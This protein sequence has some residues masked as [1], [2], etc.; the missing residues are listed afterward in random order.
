[1]VK[2]YEISELE[3]LSRKDLQAT[4]KE[5]GV[6]ANQSSVKIIQDI[7]DRNVTVEETT[8]HEE[9]VD[10]EITES[11]A[12]FQQC[13]HNVSNTIVESTQHVD[14]RHVQ[15]GLPEP[16]LLNDE[17]SRF[18]IKR[19]NKKS[20]KVKSMKP[21]SEEP[22]VRVNVSDDQSLDTHIEN[23]ITQS[24]EDVNHY[25]GPVNIEIN[26]ENFTFAEDFPNTGMNH[27]SP[28][29]VNPKRWS[30]GVTPVKSGF[31]SSMRRSSIGN[32]SMRFSMDNNMIQLNIQSKNAPGSSQKRISMDRRLSSTPSKQPLIVPKLNK[33][34]IARQEAAKTKILKMQN[35]SL[36]ISDRVSNISIKSVALPS[37]TSCETSQRKL[38]NSE[39]VKRFRMPDFSKM[40]KNQFQNSK[41]ITE[42]TERNEAVNDK[43]DAVWNTAL[44]GSSRINDSYQSDARSSS[45]FT[46]STRKENISLEKS[47]N[48][49]KARSMPKFKAIHEKLKSSRLTPVLVPAAAAAVVQNSISNTKSTGNQRAHMKNSD[50]KEN[51]SRESKSNASNKHTIKG[52]VSV[53]K[54]RMERKTNFME[55]GR[56]KRD[57]IVKAARDNKTPILNDNIFSKSQMHNIEVIPGP[58]TWA[59]TF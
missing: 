55:K 22:A 36:D 43:M 48:T 31:K 24:T 34:Q 20:T 42:L 45:V 21:E 27:S 30:M 19:A 4:A 51:N 15:E 41:S 13:Q 40:H 16:F 54:S 32:K 49:F 52:H 46:A 58:F 29:H 47:S 33:A 3:S 6:K 57:D 50:E 37:R 18:V 11:I 53:D 28:Y 9:M 8:W 35:K 2:F 38:R 25:N 12:K 10:K 23:D 59:E 5:L 7:L 14:E 26:I 1:M 39:E 56:S 44:E 17:C